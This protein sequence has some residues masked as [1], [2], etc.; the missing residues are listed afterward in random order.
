MTRLKS[1]RR[2]GGVAD[3]QHNLGPEFLIF[4][5][6]APQHV[7]QG[8]GIET[9]PAIPAIAADNEKAGALQDAKVFHHREARKL[10][11]RRCHFA[12][13]AWSL[14]EQVKH[15]SSGLVGQGLE[16]TVGASLDH[17]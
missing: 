5:D 11:E 2:F 3:I 6:P 17:M 7:A 1:W 14:G 10:R 16:Y 9:V 15:A 12:G 4:S 13:R 8:D